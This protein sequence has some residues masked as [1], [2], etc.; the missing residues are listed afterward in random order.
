MITTRDEK[1]LA[2]AI[3]RRLFSLVF[4]ALAGV[5]LVLVALLVVAAWAVVVWVNADPANAEPLLVY[6]LEE[7]YQARGGWQGVEEVFTHSSSVAIAQYQRHWNDSILLDAAGRVVFSGR[8]SN[9]PPVGAAYTLQSDDLHFPLKI[10]GQQIGALVF[11]RRQLLE[12][13][14]IF[15][16]VLFPFSLL[17]ISLGGLS[18]VIGLLLVRRVVVPLGEVIAAARL[19]ATGNLSARV[20]ASGPS[21]LRLLSDS[22]NHMAESLEKNDRE[23]RELLAVIAHELRTPLSVMRG[24]LEGIVDGIYPADGAHIAAVLEET[25]LMERLVEDLRLLALAEARQLH[26]DPRPVQLDEL[27][28]QVVDLFAAEAEEKNIGLDLQV[29]RPVAAIEADAQRLVQALGNLV[30]NALRYVPEG[31]HV[32]IWVSQSAGQVCIKVSDDGPGVAEADLPHI[33]DRFW[34]SEPSRARSSGGTGLGLAIA[35]ELVEA[36]GGTITARNYPTGGLEVEIRFNIE[37]AE[38]WKS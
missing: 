36:Q 20:T 32:S 4:R 11:P 16:P 7:H 31:R 25:Y 28:R 30:S 9:G 23:R 13:L 35:K 33:F 2:Q 19:V 22:F 10:N 18:L 27:A 24:R 8:K 34:R 12:P 17:A 14:E 3:A 1:K 5:L 38:E 37:K 26:F 21:D 29:D 6:L 15:F